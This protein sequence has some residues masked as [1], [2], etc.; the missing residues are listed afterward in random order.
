MYVNCVKYNDNYVLQIQDWLDYCI[1]FNLMKETPCIR[2]SPYSVLTCLVIRIICNKNC[3]STL[4]LSIRDC[5]E[6]RRICA[7]SHNKGY[8]WFNRASSCFCNCCNF[9][10]KKSASSMFLLLYVCTAIR[11]MKEIF[12]YRFSIYFN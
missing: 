5:G 3:S 8:N 2:S 1:I 10:F 7:Y 6:L 12:C 11:N 4:L 9:G